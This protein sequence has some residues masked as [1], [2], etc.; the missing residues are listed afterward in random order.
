MPNTEFGPEMFAMVELPPGQ[1]PPGNAIMTGPLDML[2]AQ[3]PDTV[4]RSNEMRQL[5]AARVDAAAINTMQQATRDIQVAAFADGVAR[6][7]QRLDALERRRRDR[8]RRDAERRDREQQQATQAMLDALPD[9]DAPLDPTAAAP[10]HAGDLHAE[11]PPSGPEHRRQ[12]QAAD[13][14]AL[15]NELRE[16]APPELGN[17]PEPD[18][19]KLAHPETPAQRSS[20]AISLNEE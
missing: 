4:A 9:P 15:P 10:V 12:L 2:M 6:L 5:D 19:D 20:A 13:Q 14:S 8:A 16:G 11:R 7:A 1:P 18:P 17:Y 3:L